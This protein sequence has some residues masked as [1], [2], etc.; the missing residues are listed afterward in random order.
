M[1]FTVGKEKRNALPLVLIDGHCPTDTHPFD[2]H[3]RVCDL[4][5]DN[6]EKQQNGERGDF[7][8]QKMDFEEHDCRRQFLEQ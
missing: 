5:V 8:R 3:P 6:D 2:S 7:V 4:Q 1:F